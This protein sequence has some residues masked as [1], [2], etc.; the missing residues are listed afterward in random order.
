MFNDKLILSLLRPCLTFSNFQ[1][2]K[3][4]F[5]AFGVGH[6]INYIGRFRILISVSCF[7]NVKCH[8]PC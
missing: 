8:F 6:V 7:E 5:V 1:F 2:V 4:K 3:K